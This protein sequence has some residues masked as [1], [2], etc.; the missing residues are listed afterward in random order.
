MAERLTQQE[1]MERERVLLQQ[2][3]VALAQERLAK[4]R[5]KLCKQIL[6]IERSSDSL[7]VRCMNVSSDVMFNNLWNRL[8]DDYQSSQELDID[9][10]PEVFAEGL[11]FLVPSTHQRSDLMILRRKH[12]KEI[13]QALSESEKVELFM[14]LDLNRS[15]F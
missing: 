10:Y 9:E 2:E 8:R 11:H 5:E 1:Q 13:F 15:W 4:E 3:R 14:A 6:H 12:A 7:L